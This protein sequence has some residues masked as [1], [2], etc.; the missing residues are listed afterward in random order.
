M[1]ENWTNQTEIKSESSSRIY[2]VSEKVNDGIPTDT[3]GCS[4]PGW[5]SHGKCKHLAVMGLRSAREP[6][7]SNLSVTPHRGVNPT[8][9]GR[10]S[11]SDDAYSHYDIRNGFGSPDEWIR[12]AEQRAYGRGRYK[13]PRRTWHA[14]SQA[15]DLLLLSLPKMPADAKALVK[16][17]RK[18]AYIDHPDRQGGDTERFKAM[19][20]AYE[21]LLQYY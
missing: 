9:R 16:A 20:N 5:K 11:F 12:L 17:M 8:K 7:L 10:D 21:R 3:W 15:A 6:N 1:A 18:Q 14:P 4:C 13:A 19:I 2:I